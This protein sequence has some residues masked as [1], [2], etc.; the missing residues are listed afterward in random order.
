MR[1][2]RSAPQAERDKTSAK[3]L[4]MIPPGLHHFSLPRLPTTQKDLCGEER[5][6]HIK[7]AV[8]VAERE[9][10]LTKEKRVERTKLDFRCPIYRSAIG[11]A[12]SL[13]CLLSRQLTFSLCS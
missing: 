3:R 13:I 10:H 11:Q 8:L 5:P 1:S 7:Q 9:R 2:A 4:G 12:S 6:H